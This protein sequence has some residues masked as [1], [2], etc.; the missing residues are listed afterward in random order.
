MENSTLE[1][2][3]TILGPNWKLVTDSV[4]TTGQYTV[5]TADEAVASYF[6]LNQ[7]PG[8]CG[9]CVSHNAAVSDVFRGKGLGSLLNQLR[10][11]IAKDRGFGVLLCTAI[12][13]NTRSRKILS[14]NGWKDIFYFINPKSGNKVHLSIKDL[15]I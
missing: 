7:L 15:T 10:I 14:K 9:V 11:E 8:C 3:T 12:E 5:M 4:Y 1:K 6:Y 13:G 2:I